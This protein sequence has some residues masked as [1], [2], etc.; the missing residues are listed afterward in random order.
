MWRKLKNLGHF[1]LAILANI[2]YGFPSQK[3][4]VIGITGTDGKTTTTHLIF[5]ILTAAGKKASLI[6]TIYA[7]IGSRVYDTGLHTT[8]PSYFLI[9]KLLREAVNRQEEYFVLE[10]TSH[11]L[12]QKRVWGINYLVSVITN[13][14]HEHLDYHLTYQNYLKT[15][16]N[17][18]LNSQMALINR[19]DASYLLLKKILMAKKKQFLTYSLKQ[20]ADYSFNSKTI[21]PE[22]ADFNNYNYL[23]AYSV[24][25]YLGIKEKIII[26][27]FRQFTLPQGRLETVYDGDFKVIV[28]FAHTPNAIAVL[29]Q[30][31]RKKAKGRI[32]HV[33]GS[34]GLRDTTKRPEM[35]KAS[36][37]YSNVIILT[38]E[39]YRTEDPMIIAKSIASG[40]NQKVHYQ[41]ILDRYEA[42]KKAL[43]LAKKD[44]VVVI[45]GKAHEK[46]LCRGKREYP[47][48][49]IEAVK[50][51]ITDLNL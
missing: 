17:L 13:V 29:L 51:L 40:I 19:D 50:R 35:G 6:S 38:E 39:D 37:Q 21:L 45:T 10:T 49:D 25:R 34:A 43:Q 23:A 12:D 8:T 11:S 28:D 31:L 27:T 33:F 41:I 20:P 5:A 48:N 36:S 30:F 9:Q 1:G 32:I 15:K 24:C 7:K 46:S 16:A 44:D 22:L 3:I 42:I 4:K 18:L 14:T 47:W 2:W 26:D